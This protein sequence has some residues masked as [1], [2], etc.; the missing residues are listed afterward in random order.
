MHFFVLSNDVDNFTMISY[1]VDRMFLESKI[2]N[3]TSYDE[4]E[5]KAIKDYLDLVFIDALLI[6]INRINRITAMNCE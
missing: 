5:S 2:S 3:I 6:D 4:L 1:I